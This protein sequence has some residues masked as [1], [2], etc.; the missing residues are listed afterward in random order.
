MQIQIHPFTIFSA[1]T[2]MLFKEQTVKMR[3][4]FSLQHT[5]SHQFQNKGL[6]KKK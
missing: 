1:N 3:P 6:K 5:P 4:S 2:F